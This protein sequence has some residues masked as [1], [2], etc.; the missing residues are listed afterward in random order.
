MYLKY[1]E[2]ADDSLPVVVNLSMYFI[3]FHNTLNQFIFLW[4]VKVILPSKQV[5]V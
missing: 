4:F 5:F 1:H 3:L 2:Y